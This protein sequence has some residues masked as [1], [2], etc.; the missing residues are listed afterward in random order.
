MSGDGEVMTIDDDELKEDFL[1]NVQKKDSIKEEILDENFKR[2]EKKQIFEKS[3][4]PSSI[5]KPFLKLGIVLIVLSI[6]C[7]I[8]INILPWMYIKVEVDNRG[9]EQFFYRDFVNKD[10]E[11]GIIN[12]S[13]NGTDFEEV[14]DSIFLSDC[15]NCSENSNHFIGLSK[16]DFS[17]LARY[18]SYAFILLIVIGLAFTVYE[19]IEKLLKFSSHSV[20]IVHSTFATITIII[21]TYILYILIPFLSANILQLL[22]APFLKALDISYLLIVFISPLIIIALIL[23]MIRIGFAILKMNFNDLQEK[24]ESD[25]IKKNFKPL[26]YKGGP[27]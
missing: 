9:N 27:L 3:R 2:A 7:L 20:S 18:C 16:G 21:C 5:R 1:L 6:F 26:R 8:F 19:T 10:P 11:Y 24:F 25:Y 22:N 17:T 12:E 23:L 14:I 15:K 13:G 4:K